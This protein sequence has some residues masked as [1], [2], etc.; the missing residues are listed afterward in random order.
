MTKSHA[1]FRMHMDMDV[2]SW[3]LSVY[4]AAAAGALFRNAFVKALPS[5]LEGSVGFKNLED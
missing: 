5:R 1:R 3:K 2:E 4:T